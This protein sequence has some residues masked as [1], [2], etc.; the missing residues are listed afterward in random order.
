MQYSLFNTKIQYSL[1]YI[2]NE[3]ISTVKEKNPFSNIIE[4]QE[5]KSLNI[6]A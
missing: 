4:K 6:S 5:G 1:L 2:N 3:K